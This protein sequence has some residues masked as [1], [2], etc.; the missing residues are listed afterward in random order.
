MWRVAEEVVEKNSSM[1]VS[2]E[3][4]DGV[5]MSCGDWIGQFQIQPLVDK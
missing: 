4:G 1:L 5:E 3:A 2:R